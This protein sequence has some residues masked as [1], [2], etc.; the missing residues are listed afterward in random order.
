[1]TGIC[2][3]CPKLDKCVSLNL[4]VLTF[5]LSFVLSHAGIWDKAQLVPNQQTMAFIVFAGRFNRRQRVFLPRKDFLTSENC[6]GGPH[7]ETTLISRYRLSHQLIDAVVEG[8][9]ASEWGKAT[10][11]SHAVSNAVQVNAKQGNYQL[12]IFLP[13]RGDGV[14]TRRGLSPAL[15]SPNAPFRPMAI[16]T[17]LK[18]KY[19]NFIRVSFSFSRKMS[20]SAGAARRRLVEKLCELCSHLALRPF[21]AKPLPT[22]AVHDI[23]LYIYTKY[24]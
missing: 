24:C 15:A 6:V 7:D 19:F 13:D 21:R 2:P 5:V 20:L 16:A 8:Y 1:M 22:T 17:A 14:T 4:S 10:D 23:G 18:F 3:A 9:G 12:T 11:R